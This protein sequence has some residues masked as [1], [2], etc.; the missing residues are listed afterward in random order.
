M[1]RKELENYIGL[2]LETEHQIERIAR[3]K[4]AEVLPALR[5]GDGSQHTGGDGQ[6]MAKAVE[7]RIVYEEQLR[8]QIE[9]NKRRLAAVEAAVA[10]MPNALERE[11]LRLRY[12]D[13]RYCR[14]LKWREVAIAL[15]GDDDQKF[16]DAVFRIHRTAIQNFEKISQ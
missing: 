2:R 11:V 5:Q 7:A 10:V 1:D 15:Y 8:P 16:L 4:S 13:S 6:R 9:A 12:M 14:P 3:M